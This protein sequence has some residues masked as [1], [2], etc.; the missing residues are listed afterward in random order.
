M[1]LA[2]RGYDADWIT[3]HSASESKA[4]QPDPTNACGSLGSHRDAD[5]GKKRDPRRT[6][7]AEAKI[8]A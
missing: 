1:L 5:H 7:E 2:D 3:H 6:N 8:G 4:P